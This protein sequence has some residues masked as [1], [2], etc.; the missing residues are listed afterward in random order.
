VRYIVFP[1]HASLDA[2]RPQLDDLFEEVDVEVVTGPTESG[3]YIVEGSP[4][5][6]ELL[7]FIAFPYYVL[8]ED[9]EL[10]TVH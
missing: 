3:L 4:C 10:P 7:K 2:P 6:I 8:M 9:F 1:S 5:S